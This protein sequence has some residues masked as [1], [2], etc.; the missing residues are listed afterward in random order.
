MADV[1]NPNPNQNQNQNNPQPPMN[2]QRAPT[3]GATPAR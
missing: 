2:P 1:R 3:T